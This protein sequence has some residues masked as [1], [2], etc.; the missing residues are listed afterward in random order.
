MPSMNTATRPSSPSR[1][2]RR[3]PRD[4]RRCSPVP[5]SGS[6]RSSGSPAPAWIEEPRYFL[7]RPWDPMEDMGIDMAE[8]MADKLDRSPEAFRRRNV[9]FLSRNLITL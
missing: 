2:R 9:A 7:D 4:G 1:A 6:V 5:P 3:S 8:Y